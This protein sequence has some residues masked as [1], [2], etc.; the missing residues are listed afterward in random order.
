[1]IRLQIPRII[2]ITLAIVLFATFYS[3]AAPKKMNYQGML[4][5]DQGQPMNGTVSMIFSIYDA[6]TDGDLHWS[7]IHPSVLVANGLF[8][9]VLGQGDPPVPV[10]DS[11]F[12]GHY[13]RE[14]W[15]EI[16]VN[17]EIITPRTELT[18]SP[19]A[20]DAGWTL[21]DNILY[22]SHNYCGIARKGSVMLG[23]EN[24]YDINLGDRCTTGVI[25]S[26]STGKW[27]TISGGRDN[28]ARSHED[29]N[30]GGTTVAGGVGNRALAEFSFIGGGI[31]N[32]ILSGDSWTNKGKAVVGGGSYNVASEAYATIGGGLRD[33]AN[34]YC[35]TIPGGRYCTA[36][37]RYSFASGRNAKARHDGSWVWADTT[38]EDFES[39]ASN[40]FLIRASGGVG[41]AVDA[42][43]SKA[44]AI[45][46]RYRD[47]GIVAWGMIKSDGTINGDYGIESVTRNSAGNYTITLTAT[48]V[49]RFDMC[50]VAS[51]EI[52]TPPTSAASVRIVSID[53]E[54]TNEVSVYINNGV[55]TPVDNDFCVMVTAR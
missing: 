5:D 55:F 22:T 34:G 2:F 26:G 36:S 44:T 14:R 38:D 35:S 47:N 51:P 19:Y 48:A 24:H 37:G 31:Y 1:M 15:L 54:Q 6:E 10:E 50:I 42:G 12:W 41:I 39:T 46:E 25:G 29:N 27:N 33:S 30:E 21:I 40:Q 28:V 23:W 4:T 13:I 52:D 8:S 3:S 7:E 18:S 16:S 20:L 43:G 11:L 45:G 32:S 9:V 49:S 53:I 17:S